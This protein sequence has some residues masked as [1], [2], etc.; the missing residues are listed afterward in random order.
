MFQTSSGGGLHNIHVVLLNG[1]KMQVM[2]NPS[3]TV[4][5]LLDTIVS[6]LALPEHFFFGLTTED[7]M[8]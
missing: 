4:R 3:N 1:Q 8:T 6:H 7:G 2:A 5:Q